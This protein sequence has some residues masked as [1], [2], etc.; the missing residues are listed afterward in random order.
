MPESIQHAAAKQANHETRMTP[1]QFQREER[2][3]AY[4]HLMNA[5]DAVE[6]KYGEDNAAKAAEMVAD[7]VDSSWN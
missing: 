5:L 6:K 3:A 1:E 4:R 7:E 2:M